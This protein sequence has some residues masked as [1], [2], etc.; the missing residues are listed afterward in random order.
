MYPD[1]ISGYIIMLSMDSER[2]PKTTFCNTRGSL[3]WS[4]NFARN[5]SISYGYGD[6]ALSGGIFARFDHNWSQRP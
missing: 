6:M 2:V 5:R 1:R 3:V 4:P